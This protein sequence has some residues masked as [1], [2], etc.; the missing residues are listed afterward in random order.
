MDELIKIMLTFF[1][2]MPL[3]CI[4]WILWFNALEI[5]AAICEKVKRKI[6]DEFGVVKEDKRK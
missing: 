4:A 3:L 6:L 5:F 2:G 1:V